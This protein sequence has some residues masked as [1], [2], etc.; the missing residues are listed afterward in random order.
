[1]HKGAKKEGTMQLDG[2]F[3]GVTHRDGFLAFLVQ[4]N[5]KGTG[6]MVNKSIYPTFHLAQ[7]LFQKKKKFQKKKNFKKKI[8]E[9]KKFNI[10]TP[11]ICQRCH[12]PSI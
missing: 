2:L 8:L 7:T 10:S 5:L 1:V 3:Q 12:A 4:F 6:K 11:L 9:K